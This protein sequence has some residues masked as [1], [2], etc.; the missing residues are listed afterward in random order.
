[1]SIKALLRGVLI[2]PKILFYIFKIEQF[3]RK[4]LLFY[5]FFFLHISPGYKY[6]REI[7]RGLFLSS[8]PFSYLFLLQQ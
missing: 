6:N 4:F 7:Q 3:Q 5:L 2:P 1:M 8:F